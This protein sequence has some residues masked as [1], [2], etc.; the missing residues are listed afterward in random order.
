MPFRG[1]YLKHRRE[2]RANLRH[3]SVTKAT[4]QVVPNTPRVPG[5]FVFVFSVER[6]A[7]RDLPFR[8]FSFKANSSFISN[9]YLYPTYKRRNTGGHVSMAASPGRLWNCKSTK[10]REN[11][12]GR[13][14]QQKL[15]SPGLTLR[16]D[17]SIPLLIVLKSGHV[18]QPM[19][20]QPMGVSV[21]ACFQSRSHCSRFPGALSFM[22]V[23][24]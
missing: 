3:L 15:V 16:C 9:I 1:Q 23:W 18:L 20:A 17:F 14:Q 6:G 5:H 4:I 21:Q 11:I 7:K 10:E 24:C 13:G 8:L 2:P 19:R 22:Q 12:L